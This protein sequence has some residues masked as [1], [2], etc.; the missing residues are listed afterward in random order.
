ME[1][2]YLQKHKNFPID[3]NSLR[4]AGLIFAT[5]DFYKR[6][7]VYCDYYIQF[8]IYLTILQ[9]KNIIYILLTHILEE[10]SQSPNKNV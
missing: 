2:K 5:Q 1:K 6:Q 9:Y 8:S 3:V 4:T 10:K 7:T